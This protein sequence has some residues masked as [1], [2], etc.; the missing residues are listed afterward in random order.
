MQARASSRS[1]PASSRYSVL[2][3]CNENECSCDMRS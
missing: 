3:R 1:L 2:P